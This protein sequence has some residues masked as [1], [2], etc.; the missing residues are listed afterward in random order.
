[1]VER[2]VVNSTVT[3][4]VAE[5]HGREGEGRER[6]RETTTIKIEGADFLQFVD[7]I[8]FMLKP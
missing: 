7:P 8:F 2:M 5:G 3:V 4:V 1:M 6:E